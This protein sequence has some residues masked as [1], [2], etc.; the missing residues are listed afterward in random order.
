MLLNY[1]NQLC[2][3]FLLLTLILYICAGY[4]YRV[5]TLRA[6]DDPRKRDIPLVAVLLGPITWPVL[7]FGVISLFLIKVLFYSVFLILFAIA[8]LVIRKPFLINWLKKTAEWIGDGLLGANT[9]LLKMV[10]GDGAK[11]TTS[12]DR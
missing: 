2:L 11:K 3:G 12:S 8:L 4:A 10:F 7:L 5:N 1:S 9:L 6:A